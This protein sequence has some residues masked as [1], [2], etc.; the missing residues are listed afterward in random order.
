MGL[1][2]ALMAGMIFIGAYA[3][4]GLLVVSIIATIFEY[5]P[6]ALGIIVLLAVFGAF[7]DK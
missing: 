7:S 6:L 2:I 4:V 5:W 3:F 1:F